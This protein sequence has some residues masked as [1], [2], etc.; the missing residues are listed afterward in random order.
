MAGAMPCGN[1]HDCSRCVCLFLARAPVNDVLDAAQ[2]CDGTPLASLATCIACDAHPS[3]SYTRRVLTAALRRWEAAG[4]SDE[5][6]V[7]QLHEHLAAVLLREAAEDAVWMHR[8]FTLSSGAALWVK[9][10]SDYLAAQTSGFVWPCGLELARLALRTPQMFNGQRIL[11][12]GAGTGVAAL[13]L[14]THTSPAALFVSD[15][16]GDAAANIAANFQ[17]NAVP[18]HADADAWHASKAGGAASA[19]VFPLHW[20]DVTPELASALSPTLII[21]ADVCYD[22]EDA[23]AL[24]HALALLLRPGDAT[25]QPTALVLLTQ[26]SEATVAAFQA[27]WQSESLA[28]RDRTAELLAGGS[29]NDAPDFLHLP[30]TQ[31]HHGGQL[32]AFTLEWELPCGTVETRNHTG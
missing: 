14:A 26:R 27:A 12:L 9:A 30:R 1:P 15:A 2:C 24:A 25:P 7:E 4:N 6:V 3:S 19:H 31:Q 32:R 21:A 10:S 5:D 22:P 20:S 16:N 11:E 29:S 28:V 18:H 17:L 23:P 13:V 8:R